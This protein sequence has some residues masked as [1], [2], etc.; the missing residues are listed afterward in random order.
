[1]FVQFKMIVIIVMVGMARSATD[2]NP[3]VDS[4]Y[5]QILAL[6]CICVQNSVIRFF[7]TLLAFIHA[8]LQGLQ[9]H[10]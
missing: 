4:R 6:R 7:S 3:V 10:C 9:N 2:S 5:G 8:G 1:M